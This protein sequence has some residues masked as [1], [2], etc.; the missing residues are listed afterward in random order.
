[1]KSRVLR[2][3][4]YAL[5]LL[6]A[7]L[8][9]WGRWQGQSPFIDLGADAGRVATY[10]A[11]CDYPENFRRAARMWGPV[12]AYN[13][14]AL[15]NLLRVLED[16]FGDFG[17]AT[18]VLLAPVV[19]FQSWGFYLVG[20]ELLRRRGW[21]VLY[22][23]L[24]LPLV[25]IR[26]PQ[27]THWGI[28]EDPWARH[29]YQAALPFLWWLSFKYV[30]RPR[31]WPWIL[32]A[33]GALSYLHFRSGAF[34]MVA[35]WAGFMV[36]LT[37]LVPSGTARWRLRG[38]LTLAALVL[39][40][41]P[42]LYFLSEV[43]AQLASAVTGTATASATLEAQY[44]EYLQGLVAAPLLFALYW[45]LL[46][47][48]SVLLLALVGLFWL[49]RH[50]EERERL[51][52]RMVLVWIVSLLVLSFGLHLVSPRLSVRIY[53][54]DLI[55]GLRFLVPIALTLAVWFLVAWMR[56]APARTAAS[57]F[58]GR[59][60]G[61]YL[62]VLFPLVAF[63]AYP[64]ASGMEHFRSVERFLNLRSVDLTL[65]LMDRVPDPDSVLWVRPYLRLA[66]KTAL[67][68]GLLAC[69]LV[70]LWLIGAGW[71][72]AFPWQV[73]KVVQRVGAS[74]EGR[75]PR[76]AALSLFSLALLW[77]WA[78][79]DGGGVALL[80]AGLT[81][82]RPRPVTAFQ[83]LYGEALPNLVPPKAV[84]FTPDL[85]PWEIGYIGLRDY[86]KPS[87][88]LRRVVRWNMEHVQDVEQRSKVWLTL[89]RKVRA[90]YM[91]TVD[92]PVDV[93]RKNT[94]VHVLYGKGRAVL[95]RIVAMSLKEDR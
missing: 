93:W 36:L 73:G 65:R 91:V 31:V 53:R 20:N 25:W 44:Q 62:A 72:R 86:A 75:R 94:A 81:T 41:P 66:L 57:A 60:F 7:L 52:A 49:R 9:F 12:C 27:G 56:Q 3:A 51:Q 63:G 92:I 83:R 89:A 58:S 79:S 34:W 46:P 88:E 77:G 39:L 26:F 1:M 76:W 90:T 78:H 14:I 42:V 50:G 84:V 82:H 29:L 87:V 38:A 24:H 33:N 61:V 6:L 17:T 4:P 21:A 16:V 15:A 30:T 54:M 69:F 64:L 19:F 47:R 2:L 45:V 67:D 22:A 59:G 37:P 11:K 95:L 85:Y 28:Y 71:A 48:I 80:K 70:L 23:L 5:F 8:V 10:A 18:V 35:L 32:L 55:R 74:I 40:V 43:P 13:H 68:L